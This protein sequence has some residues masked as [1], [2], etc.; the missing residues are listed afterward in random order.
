MLK[1]TIKDGVSKVFKKFNFLKIAE[2]L[3]IETVA[4]KHETTI[5]KLLR[6]SSAFFLLSGLFNVVILALSFSYDAM[7]RSLLLLYLINF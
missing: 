4:A 3:E 2:Y 6:I 1:A 7:V 5:I